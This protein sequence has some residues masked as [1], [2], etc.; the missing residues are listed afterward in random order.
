VKHDARL[1]CLIEVQVAPHHDIE[2][3]VRI[4]GIGDAGRF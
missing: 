1:A 4:T 2:K 3:I